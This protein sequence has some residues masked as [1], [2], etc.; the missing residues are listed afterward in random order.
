MVFFAEADPPATEPIE[1]LLRVVCRA[2]VVH[3][4]ARIV[5]LSFIEPRV[6]SMLI[7]M[8]TSVSTFEGYQLLSRSVLKQSRPWIRDRCALQLACA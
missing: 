5:N 1:R 7:G 8:L 6:Q 3:V 2:M 4:D